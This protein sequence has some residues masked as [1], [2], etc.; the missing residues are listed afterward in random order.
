[1]GD[2]NSLAGTTKA[3]KHSALSTDGGFLETAVTGVT[4]LSE[5]SIVYGNA[6]EIVTEL[7]AG[8][9]GNALQISSGV[10][11]WGS[12]GGIW[13]SQGTASAS[14]VQSQLEVTGISGDPDIVQILFSV[15]GDTVNQHLALRINDVQTSTYFSRVF[16]FYNAF[17]Y[18]FFDTKTEFWLDR[19]T[20]NENR[21]GCIWLFKPNS[22]LSNVG[23]TFRS[24][25]SEVGSTNASYITMSGGGNNSITSE[26][27]SIQV[28]FD[29]GNIMGNIQVNSMTYQ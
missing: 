2:E 27:S 16:G 29:V 28:L 10:P 22:N 21:C 14:S 24:S 13:I 9:E 25:D 26:L 17:D 23:W 12:S 15:D 7:T 5:G 18:D 6:T 1:M 11:A 4:N 8:S 20:N 3:H 19:E